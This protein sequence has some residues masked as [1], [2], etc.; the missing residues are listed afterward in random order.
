MRA[1]PREV[2]RA[3]EVERPLNAR[4]ARCG[5]GQAPRG[6]AQATAAPGGGV[7]PGRRGK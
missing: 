5:A 7:G 1:G 3:L 2:G 4:R 6:R